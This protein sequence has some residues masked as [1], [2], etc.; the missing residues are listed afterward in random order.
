LRRRTK[1]LAH[2]NWLNVSVVGRGRNYNALGA[3]I[4]VTTGNVT[5]TR[6]V[7]LACQYVSHAA[8]VQLFGLG[9]TDFIG[10]IEVTWPDGTLTSQYSIS[11][12]QIVIK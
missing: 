5:Q 6:V 9:D 10:Q 4:K 1:R 2:D 8:I 12:G 3:V 7:N 11:A